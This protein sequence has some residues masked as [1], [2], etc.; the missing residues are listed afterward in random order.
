[1]FLALA[2]CLIGFAARAGNPGMIPCS[3][4]VSGHSLISGGGICVVDGGAAPGTGTVTSVQ[5]SGGTTGLTFSGGPI[6]TSGT[7]TLGGTLAVASGGTGTSTPA[8]VAGSNI[9]ITGSWPNQTIAASGGGAITLGTS[10][11]VTNPQRSGDAT[12]GLFSAATSTVSVATGGT[13]ALRVNAQQFLGIGSS[14]PFEGIDAFVN[15]KVGQSPTTLTTVT[16]NCLNTVGTTVD[17]VST[18]GYAPQGYLL[19]P[20]YNPLYYGT[21]YTEVMSYTGTTATSF[22][23][24]TR[25]LFGTSAGTHCQLEPLSPYLFMAKDSG[26]NP[27][28]IVAANG[29][30]GV[31]NAGPLEILDVGGN[32]RVGKVPTPESYLTDNCA[33]SGSLTMDIASSSGYASSGTYIINQEAISYSSIIGNTFYGLLRG[34][35]DTT[36]ATQCTSLYGSSPPMDAVLF[37]VED[38]ANNPKFAVLGSAKSG[39]NTIIPKQMIDVNGNMRFGVGPSSYTTVQDNP[40]S[41]ASYISYMDVGSTANYPTSGVLK[42]GNE[43]MQYTGTNGSQFLGLVRGTY[44]SAV[45]S[46]ALNTPVV[47]Y[48]LEVAQGPNQLPMHVITGT[49][50]VGIGTYAPK[51]AVDISGAVGI[52]TTYAGVTAAPTNG[53]IVAGSVGIGTSAPIAPLD[54]NGAYASTGI[55]GVS[56][57][58]GTLNPVTTVVTNGIV[59]HC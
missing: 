23:G 21:S 24:L 26:N 7:L 54:V 37:H 57:S 4:F 31:G 13:E 39:F 17:V 8:L 16:D 10:A 32:E 38:T 29:S 14:S 34:A 45:T 41:G 35:Y 44:G 30:V 46:H 42:V 27:K 59:T 25:G 52:G 40:M 48:I 20:N 56:C 11:S 36:A 2:L 5:A 18:T 22:T 9:T 53:M 6:T 47:N 19:L 43:W 15:M 12:T 1:M 3:A 55:V 51:N 28:L 50:Q 58:A 49:G 33:G